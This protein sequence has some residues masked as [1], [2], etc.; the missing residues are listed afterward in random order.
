MSALSGAT[1]R[2]PVRSQVRCGYN[3]ESDARPDLLGKAVALASQLEKKGP[4]LTDVREETTS[5]EEPP[6][7][8]TPADA[9]LEVRFEAE[10]GGPLGLRPA[11]HGSLPN[12]FFQNDVQDE[13]G[14]VTTH[15]TLNTGAEETSFSLSFPPVPSRAAG[16]ALLRP[17]LA[18]LG[19]RP[20]PYWATLSLTDAAKT[21]S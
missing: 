19:G 4:R 18:R 7:P 9:L 6:T 2:G 12:H 8:A 20:V 5:S 17:S 16:R 15:P 3:A 1:G 10:E 14:R 21:R 11:L 13:W